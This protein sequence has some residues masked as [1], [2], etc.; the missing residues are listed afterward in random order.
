[1]SYRIRLVLLRARRMVTWKGAGEG[2]EESQRWN[3]L[4]VFSSS[5]QFLYLSTYGMQVTMGDTE[6]RTIRSL[7]PGRSCLTHGQDMRWLNMI[8]APWRS[9]SWHGCP[10]SI[11]PS[12]RKTPLKDRKEYNWGRQGGC[13]AQN[14]SAMEKFWGRKKEERR[15]EKGQNSRRGER[16]NSK[17]ESPLKSLRRRG[18]SQCIFMRSTWENSIEMSISHGRIWK[19][20]GHALYVSLWLTVPWTK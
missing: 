13:T 6:M 7:A 4:L 17:G 14:G 19:D 5:L 12:F 15:K 16:E 10:S 8:D 11:A 2:E 9:H 20:G 3:G 1:M 18:T